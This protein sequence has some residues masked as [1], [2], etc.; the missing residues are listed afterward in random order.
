MNQTKFKRVAK[1]KEFYQIAG[2]LDS[3]RS[4]EFLS[5]DAH[6]SS[7]YDWDSADERLL[8]HTAKYVLVWNRLLM[9]SKGA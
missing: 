1:A 9:E 3:R 7:N 2:K 8:V 5:K 6:P 4:V